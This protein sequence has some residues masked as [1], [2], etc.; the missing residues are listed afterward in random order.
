MN[1]KHKKM[2]FFQ[3][4]L[5]AISDFRFYPLMLKVDST[6][7]VIG[8]FI[9]FMLIITSIMSIS[10][11]NFAL[12]GI[13]SV[14]DKYD[15]NIP[16]FTLTDG[17]LDVEK[18]EVYKVMNDFV[19]ILDTNYNYDEITTLEDYE[20]YDVYDNRVYINSDAITYE[21]DIEIAGKEEAQVPQ[22]LLL[23]E[24]SEDFNKETLKQYILEIKES[25][26]SKVIIFVS[27][28]T[29][30]FFIYA[31]SKIFEIIL[32]SIMTSL[33]ATISGIKLHFK[34]YVKIALYIITLPYILET[35]SMVY[36]GEISEA[37]FIVSNLLAYVY[38]L[39]A[40]RAVKLDA[41]ILIM[42]NP[43]KIKK[44]K[45]G[46]TVIGVEDL[47]DKQD[48]N[49]EIETNTEETTSDENKDEN[50]EQE[51]KDDDNTQK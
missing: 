50:Q 10:F 17:V 44:S 30:T 19:I 12:D 9:I 2:N 11:Y 4:T 6:A 42:N 27:L 36:L 21:S 15:E 16:Q 39:Y 20:E 43:N 7:T 3:K 1:K 26:Y 18:Q 25:N 31:F 33:V 5:L 41:F 45:D 51:N 48:E 14:L 28:F 49:K 47:E 8:H 46:R 22:Q 29:A 23:S 40:I 24:I 35:I 38:I 32:Y 13:D 37:A 34:N